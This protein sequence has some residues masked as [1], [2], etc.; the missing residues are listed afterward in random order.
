MGKMFLTALNVDSD[1]YAKGAELREGITF[2]DGSVFPQSYKVP[3]LFS[4]NGRCT[5]KK[6]FIEEIWYMVFRW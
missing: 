3:F 1:M 2:C 6:E 5:D 4:A